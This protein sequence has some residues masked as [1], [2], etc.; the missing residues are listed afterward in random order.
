[1]AGIVDIGKIDLYIT[2]ISVFKSLLSS[3]RVA[4]AVNFIRPPTTV[5]DAALLCSQNPCPVHLP[6]SVDCSG[7]RMEKHT[8]IRLQT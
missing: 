4:L 6:D 2:Y 7:I 3:P 5:T 1:M 8:K